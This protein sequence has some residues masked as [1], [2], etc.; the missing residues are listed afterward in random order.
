[1]TFTESRRSW[2]LPVIVG[3]LCGLSM[4]CVPCSVAGAIPA[5]GAPAPTISGFSV[6]PQKLAA[7][8]GSVVLSAAGD[9]RLEVHI[10][11]E[12][13]AERTSSRHLVHERHC[14]PTCGSFT[15]RGA[16]GRHG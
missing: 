15:E 6:T 5:P 16:S 7:N 10:R 9:E 4:F 14:E 11:F 1:M 8:G 13:S 3:A 2:R 12:S